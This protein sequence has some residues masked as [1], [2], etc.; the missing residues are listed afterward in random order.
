MSELNETKTVMFQLGMAVTVEVQT[1]E[2][3]IIEFFLA[4]LS[5]AE[6]ESIWEH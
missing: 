5:G 3:R 2:Q 1:G 6:N 4:P